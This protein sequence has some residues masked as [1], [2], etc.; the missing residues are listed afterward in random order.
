MKPASAAFLSIV[1]CLALLL[2]PIPAATM[3]FE[4]GRTVEFAQDNDWFGGTDRWDTNTIRL[5]HISAPL[6][7][8]PASGSGGDIRWGN[9]PGR[10]SPGF[11]QT[12]SAAVGQAMFTPASKSTAEL[13][14]DDRPYAGW[15]YLA[16]GL[17]EKNTRQLDDLEL[18]MGVVGPWSQAE[19]TQKWFHTKDPQGWDNQLRNEPGFILSWERYL[20]VTPWTGRGWG[21]DAIPHLGLAVG[22]VYTYANTGFELRWGYNL[23]SDFGTSMAWR[24]SRNTIGPSSPDD[25][26]F[27]GRWG[28]HFFAGADGRYVLRNIFLDGNT[29]R[30]SHSVDKEEWVADLSAGF[31]FMLKRVKVT[32]THALRTKE[33]EG[34]PE[35]QQYGSVSFAVTF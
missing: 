30:D 16:L 13:I 8:D 20:R 7:E 15:L 31:A 12:W 3:S 14:E 34:Q 25:P 1:C 24:A 21:F 26:R 23:P 17:Q 10:G 29:W 33:F 22:N 27:H 35:N 28:F 11:F 6:G 9:L 2:A 5:S 19:N 4:D 32:Y 18:T